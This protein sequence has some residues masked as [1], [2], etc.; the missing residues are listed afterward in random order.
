MKAW[1]IREIK[2]EGYGLDGREVS[3]QDWGDVPE[4]EVRDSLE[5]D[6]KPRQ[7]R[8]D[9]IEL[10][11][12]I[13]AGES[14]GSISHYAGDGQHHTTRDGTFTHHY[15]AELMRLLVAKQAELKARGGRHRL[16]QTNAERSKAADQ[17]RKAK[18]KC[19]VKV[20]ASPE[21]R[22]LLRRVS[23][24]IQDAPAA[25]A[26]LARLLDKHVADLE[27]ALKTDRAEAARRK[28]MAAAEAKAA[29]AAE[30]ILK[31]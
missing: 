27:A 2:G 31:G 14:P 29:K 13:V 24:Y 20:V 16:Y 15:T 7:V 18:G 25:A 28:V 10:A 3:V 1:Y 23:G 22:E 12:K 17:N 5:A 11:L 19:V 30:R 9:D 8:R 21:E 6:A 4:F 26:V